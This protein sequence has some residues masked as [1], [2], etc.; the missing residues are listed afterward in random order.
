MDIDNL[1]RMANR[2]ADFFDAMPDRQEATEG[3]AM[4]LKRYWTPG[5]RTQLANAV[6]SDG[7]HPLVV[8]A[9]HK[10]MGQML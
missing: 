6:D 7:L 3:V 10:K 1:V 4:H 9:L 5:M 8:A 2:I